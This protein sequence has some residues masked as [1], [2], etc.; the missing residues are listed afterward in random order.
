[1]ENVEF[2]KF[3]SSHYLFSATSVDFT[4]HLCLKPPGIRR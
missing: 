4:N 2:L 3:R 1:M